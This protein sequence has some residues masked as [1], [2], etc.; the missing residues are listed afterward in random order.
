MDDEAALGH[1]Q[2]LLKSSR[3][4]VRVRGPVVLGPEPTVA[5][6]LASAPSPLGSGAADAS[7]APVCW[8]PEP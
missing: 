5:P 3:E 2:E 4:V 6:V 8:G 7:R 1:P